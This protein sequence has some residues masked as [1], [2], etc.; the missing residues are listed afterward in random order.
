MAI[1]IR[2]YYHDEQLKVPDFPNI[3]SE[4]LAYP[5]YFGMFQSILSI[6]SMLKESQ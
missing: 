2:I 5:R 6:K 4:N 3:I 1:S